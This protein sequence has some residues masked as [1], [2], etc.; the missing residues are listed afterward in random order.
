M[1]LL[2]KHYPVINQ[3]MEV[4]NVKSV[5]CVLLPCVKYLLA[6]TTEIAQVIITI[7]QY[8]MLRKY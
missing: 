7:S 3:W 4:M 1:K 2:V 6:K 5:R 8:H